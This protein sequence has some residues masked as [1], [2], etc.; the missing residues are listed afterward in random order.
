MEAAGRISVTRPYQKTTGPLVA[1]ALN[2][3]GPLVTSGPV[4]AVKVDEILER[5]QDLINPNWRPRHAKAI[6]EYG[7][8]RYEKLAEY[9]RKKTAEGIVRDPQAYLAGLLNR[10][11]RQQSVNL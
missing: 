11:F 9:T 6:Q 4:E 1:K 7:I 2:T 8:Y 10:L 5:Y 3:T